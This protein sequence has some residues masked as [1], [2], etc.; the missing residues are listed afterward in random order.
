VGFMEIRNKINE[1]FGTE[2]SPGEVRERMN[3]A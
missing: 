2:L 3:G 1:E